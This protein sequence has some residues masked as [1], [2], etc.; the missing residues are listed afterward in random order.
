MRQLLITADVPSSPILVTLMMD[1]QCSSKMLV[2][3]RATRRNITEDDGILC[4]TMK[5]VLNNCAAAYIA[6]CYK[7]AQSV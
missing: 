7:A 2:R 5:S 3:T 1:E 6:L 4:V